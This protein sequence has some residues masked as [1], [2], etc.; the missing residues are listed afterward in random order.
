MEGLS[1]YKNIQEIALCAAKKYRKDIDGNPE[2]YAKSIVSHYRSNSAP[3][4]IR[5]NVYYQH[6]LEQYP[7]TVQ[8]EVIKILESKRGQ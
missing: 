8:N 7:N 6:L 3:E 1:T 2:S 5:K 4:Q